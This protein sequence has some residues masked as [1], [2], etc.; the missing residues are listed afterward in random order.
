M[1]A[2]V[3]VGAEAN[4][5]LLVEPRLEVP[6]RFN[7]E[8][9]L[10]KFTEANVREALPER[11]RSASMELTVRAPVVSVVEL[12]TK[13]RVP[14]VSVTVPVSKRRLLL[15]EPVLSRVRVP[16]AVVAILPAPQVPLAPLSTTVPRLA[17]R[18]PVARF[19][20]VRVT[21]P[22]PDWVSPLAPVPAL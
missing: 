2:G 4:R 11:L 14:P 18:E 16:P 6:E 19:A 5:S 15:L 10:G 20:A 3:S 17:V 9:G 1:V 7:E 8:P 12:P 13:L 22:V 21:V